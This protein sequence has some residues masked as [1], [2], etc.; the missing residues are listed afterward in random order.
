[1]TAATYLA[2][3]HEFLPIEGGY[4][5]HWSLAADH[6]LGCQADRR[7]DDHRLPR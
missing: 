5:D 6:R 3:W 2:P 1:M 7:S 4:S